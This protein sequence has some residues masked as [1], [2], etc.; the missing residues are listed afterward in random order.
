MYCQRCGRALIP[1]FWVCPG[2]KSPAKARPVA[3]PAGAPRSC[4]GC[5]HDISKESGACPSCKRPVRLS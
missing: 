1:A 3:A 2:C 5:G 4:R